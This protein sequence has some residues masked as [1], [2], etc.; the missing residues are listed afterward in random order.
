MDPESGWTELLLDR[1]IPPFS[2]EGRDKKRLVLLFSGKSSD[3]I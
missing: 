3:I 1:K 2:E